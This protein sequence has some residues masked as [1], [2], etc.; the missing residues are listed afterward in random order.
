MQEK[1]KLADDIDLKIVAKNT[2]G[3]SGADLENV[4][5]EA[6]LLAAEEELKGNS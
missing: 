3:F 6:R 1:K 4:L 5:N 2:A